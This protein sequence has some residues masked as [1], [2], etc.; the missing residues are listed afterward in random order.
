[1]ISGIMQAALRFEHFRL[2]ELFTGFSSAQ[3][4]EPVR[5]PVANH[6]QSW[7]AGS[8]PFMLTTLL[9]LEPNAF[10]RRLRIVRPLLPEFV[11]RLD[12][13][14]LAVGAAKVDLRFSR[15]SRDVAVDILRLDGE[16][17][18]K[19]EQGPNVERTPRPPG[20]ASSRASHARG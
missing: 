10:D 19:V 4:D 13:L 11:Q 5:Y 3:F 15:T 17:E 9:G 14:R 1:V 12:V 8:I 16:L 2:P 20:S 18:V 7:G 6:P